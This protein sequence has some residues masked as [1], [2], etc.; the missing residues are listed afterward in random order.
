[1]NIRN[2]TFSLFIVI[3]ITLIAMSSSTHT[4]QSKTKARLDLV[5]RVIA[6]C[7]KQKGD[8][9]GKTE[10][11]YEYGKENGIPEKNRLSWAIDGYG[12]LPVVEQSSSC[13]LTAFCAAYSKGK[14]GVD[15]CG[16]GDDITLKSCP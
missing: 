1:M 15:E 7:R 2:V 13:K 11:L 9:I 16:K 5:E 10:C 12:N 6:D 3:V 8:A 4:R 14:N